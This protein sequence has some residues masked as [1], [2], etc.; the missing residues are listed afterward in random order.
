[1]KTYIAKTLF[2]LED[3]LAKELENL[4]AQ[5]VEV[6]NRAVAFDADK[7]CLY[8]VH[9]YSFLTVRVIE[10]FFTFSA[11]N[12]EDLYQQV[13]NFPWKK[14]MSVDDSFKI[15]P[16]VFSS[17]FKHS[18]YASLK[19]KDAICD[20][21]RQEEG[22]RPDVN[23]KN[24]NYIFSLNIRENDVQIAI[25]ATDK[26]LHQR[27]Y[28]LEGG[29]APLNEVLAAGIIALSGWDGKM[30]FVD[31]MCGSGTMVIE[32]LL[33]ANHRP[34]GF[35]R[36]KFGFMNWP[37]FDEKLWK[38]IR[39]EAEANIRQDYPNIKGIEIDSKIF[40]NAKENMVRA[41]FMPIHHLEM[42]N[43]FNYKP[44]EK[45]GFLFLNPPYDERIK[46][47]SINEFYEKIGDHLKKNFKGWTAWIISSNVEA[48]KHIGLRT[49][50][51]IKLFNGKLE[52]RL[53][54]FELF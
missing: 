4:G 10:P 11:S 54:K 22:K 9:L 40:G 39:E 16:V 31:G 51:K 41:G 26:S 27:K 44:R 48:R 25:D 6:L 47:E 42:G 24:P 19:V 8:K 35:D 20:Y 1:M 53:M 17:T 21:F 46:D 52:C 18:L 2:G 5:N 36:Y 43:F 33:R 12:E 23:I 38:E 29:L 3:E 7:A 13:K 30:P 50:A 32:A 45:E 28:R 37:D 34:P 49:A 14:Y 15:D